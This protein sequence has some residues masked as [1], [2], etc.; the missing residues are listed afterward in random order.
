MWGQQLENEERPATVAG[1]SSIG[2]ELV[3]RGRKTA[4]RGPEGKSPW[5]RGSSEAELQR[6]TCVLA[7]RGWRPP[8]FGPASSAAF[9]SLSLCPEAERGSAQN[10]RG[11]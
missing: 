6:D 1:R 10:L 5:R 7:H 4:G 3:P 11:N 2:E 9:F 8:A